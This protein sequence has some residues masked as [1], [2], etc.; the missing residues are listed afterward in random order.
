MR[1]FKRPLELVDLWELRKEETCAYN[2]REFTATWNVEFQTWQESQNSSKRIKTSNVSDSHNLQAE[3]T[4]WERI[5]S[6]NGDETKNGDHTAY[7][8][9]FSGETSVSNFHP[10]LKALI[11]VY[12]RKFVSVQLNM[13]VYVIFVT[14]NPLFIW[15]VLGG[16]L[17]LPSG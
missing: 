10:L 5:G 1:S 4:H 15:Y 3:N 11:K 2:S 6:T 14:L 9:N 8:K 13:G 16:W 12:W 17:K 7:S